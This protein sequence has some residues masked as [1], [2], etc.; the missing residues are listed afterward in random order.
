MSNSTPA[1]ELFLRS[2]K[3]AIRVLVVVGLF[4]CVINLLMLVG[5]I[6]M[7]Q[8]YDRVLASGSIPTLAYLTAVAAGLIL[9]GAL[10]EA[11]RARVLVRMSGL[12]ESQLAET[13]YDKLMDRAVTGERASTRPLQDAERL[14]NFLTGSGL[15]FFF[16]APWT[17]IFLGVMFLLH[18]YLFYVAGTG[19]AL[20]F[21][22]ALVNNAATREELQLAA[23]HGAQATAFAD[24]MTRQA[25]AVE[26]MGMQPGLKR[27]WLAKNRHALA[28]QT[29]ASDRAGIMTAMSKFVRPVLQVAILCTGAWLALAQQISPGTMVAAAIIMGRALAP[30]EGAINNWRSFVLARD[31]YG[32]LRD[33]FSAEERPVSQQ[34]LPRP[35]GNLS[36]EKLVLAPP[37]MASPVIKGISF[38]VQ[39]GEILGVIG[40]STAGKST[41]ARGMVGIWPPA[42]G[43]IRLDGMDVA[44]WN[45]AEL[46]PHIG[47]LP[48]SVELLEGSVSQNI[49]RFSEADPQTVIEAATLANVHELVLRLPQGYDTP[50]GPN[51]IALS[52]GQ[53]QRIGLA[54]AVFNS[55]S[56]IVLDE[57]N[58]NLDSE[59]EEALRQ[60]LLKLK[61][62]GTTVI[63]IA[64]RPS[65]LAAADKLLALR[66][67]LIEQFG[68]RDEVLG[69]FSRGSKSAAHS[70]RPANVARLKR[71]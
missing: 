66:D 58:S 41:L 61:Q 31:S 30:V 67:G 26:A 53:L 17:P 69:T 9:V 11:V 48:Q 71:A 35:K 44:R 20:L 21:C 13:L 60:V 14:R 68:P 32:R 12:L 62:N 55:P 34:P 47:Y 28:H 36:V 54:R 70:K 39:A 25:E 52:G 4:S 16:D 57:P 22:I 3:T 46:G 33:V 65:V 7:L 49:A 63:V 6:Y 45:P 38:S 15:F 37:G 23:S 56:F 24:N 10:L 64:H 43:S 19:A 5:P 50:V 1:H 2:R 59:G 27:M 51:G 8:V 40:P 29:T 18:P 42:S